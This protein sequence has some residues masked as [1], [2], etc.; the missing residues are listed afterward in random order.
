MFEYK[1]FK[2]QGREGL[3]TVKVFKPSGGLLD[4]FRNVQTA[5]REISKM[6]NGSK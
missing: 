6:L 2:I 5:K 4:S 3:A 1:G